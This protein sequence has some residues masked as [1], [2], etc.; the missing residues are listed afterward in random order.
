MFTVLYW[1]T[2]L[3]RGV[4]PGITA[5]ST[6]VTNTMNL[7]DPFRIKILLYMLIPAFGFSPAPGIEIVK[8]NV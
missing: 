1:D 5:R 7:L 4:S 2:L 8:L 6:L 3:N